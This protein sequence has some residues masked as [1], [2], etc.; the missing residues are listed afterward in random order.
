LTAPPSLAPEEKEKNEPPPPPKE[1]E[2]EIEPRGRYTNLR[3]GHWQ[4]DRREDGD[5]L[6]IIIVYQLC[7]VL[8]NKLRAKGLRPGWYQFLLVVA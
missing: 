1:K 8:G 3:G 7:R 5:V 2:K 6:E 4:T